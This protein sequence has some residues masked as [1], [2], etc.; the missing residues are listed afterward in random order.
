MSQSV[1]HL[2]SFHVKKREN[3]RQKT[4]FGVLVIGDVNY[5]S[6]NSWENEQSS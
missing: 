3:L 2:F 6:E 4:Q 1:L 5:A